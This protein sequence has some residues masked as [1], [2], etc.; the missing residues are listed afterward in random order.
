M[1]SGSKIMTIHEGNTNS[2]CS[3]L[4]ER[5]K[6]LR[7]WQDEQRKEISLNQSRGACEMK[8]PKKNEFHRDPTNSDIEALQL[9][10]QG[11]MKNKV[12]EQRGNSSEGEN[13]TSLLEFQQSSSGSS[14]T[15]HRF[16]SENS[17]T[18]E[19]QSVYQDDRP[20]QEGLSCQNVLGNISDSISTSPDLSLQEECKMHPVSENGQSKVVQTQDNQI[21]DNINIKKSIVSE[22]PIARDMYTLK[23]N[24]T[25][26]DDCKRKYQGLT[27]FISRHTV[28]NSVIDDNVLGINS[29][30]SNE[31]SVSQPQLKFTYLK[32]GQGTARFGM[33]PLRFRRAQNY[34]QEQA[35]ERE[36]FSGN[37]S[38][39][40]KSIDSSQN[41]KL[42]AG[43]VP[44]KMLQLQ[45]P[46]T[47]LGYEKCKEGTIMH[48]PA[49][50]D[51]PVIVTRSNIQQKRVTPTSENDKQLLKEQEELSAFE[52]L[53]ELADD[54]S[55][56]SNSSTV[57]RLLQRGLHSSSSTPLKSPSSTPSFSPTFHLLNNK[58]ILAKCCKRDDVIAK[59]SKMELANIC[60]DE[61]YRQQNQ[62]PLVNVSIVLEQ[63]KRFVRLEDLS[64]SGLSE[65]ELKSVLESFIESEN[66][67]NVG[68]VSCFENN[69]KLTSSNPTSTPAVNDEPQ[70][71]RPRVHFQPEGVQVLEY[72]LS[73]SDGENTLTDM[74]SITD[75]TDLV[76][77]SDLEVLTQIHVN[78]TDSEG[79]QKFQSLKE[80]HENETPDHVSSSGALQPIRLQFSPPC[81]PKN[82]ASHY[83]WSIFGKEEPGK[84]ANHS[85]TSQHVSSKGSRRVLISAPEAVQEKDKKLLETN[86][87][88]VI[89]SIER[90]ES[91]S[92]SKIGNHEEVETHKA[93]LMAKV[94]ELEKEIDFYKKG[95][96]KIKNLQDS[97]QSERS[98]LDHQKR[99]FQEEMAK[100]KVKFQEYLDAERNKLWKEKQS[101]RNPSVSS[102]REQSMEI[103]FLKEQ[104][105][106]LQE[107]LQKR[108]DLHN[109]AVKKLNEKIRLQE[110]EVKSLKLKN[111]SLQKSVQDMQ[112]KQKID[113][114]NVNKKP[115]VN[116]KGVIL[117]GK[118]K[119]KTK[120]ATI[121]SINKSLDKVPVTVS[122]PLIDR[123]ALLGDMPVQ[124]KMS[125]LGRQSPSNSLHQ[126]SNQE[127]NHTLQSF[128]QANKIEF[129][130]SIITTGRNKNAQESSRSDN[131]DKRR[132]LIGLH[133]DKPTNDGEEA[134]EIPVGTIDAGF[135][136][137]KFKPGITSV[138]ESSP[139]T[140]QSINIE[141]TELQLGDG[142]KEIIYANG[143]KKSIHS[144]G[145]IIISYYNGDKKEIHQDRTVYVYGTDRTSHTTF[146][147]GK[148]ILEFPNG[149]K[150]TRFTDGSSEIIFPDKTCKTVLPDGTEVCTLPNGTIVHTNADGFKVMEFVSGQKE[151]H[152]PEQKRR[153]YPD[154]TVK[155]LHSDGSTET[156]YKTGR[157]RVKDREGNIL[158][159]THQSVQ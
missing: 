102:V 36:I 1:E 54:S 89:E 39:N 79:A 3:A 13:S 153:E 78:A 133:E 27:N 71:A 23:C 156:R 57:I 44:V 42:K 148:E 5:L 73:E 53:E 143:N 56:S 97:L 21:L 101:V 77:T 33:K 118:S 147:N 22:F 25:N 55:F 117:T 120:T 51:E 58:K 110:L 86:G 37:P 45:D 35:E 94:C 75:D 83:I 76:T 137:S 38:V 34:V 124:N 129:S 19:D 144:D 99:S 96:V 123:Q 16:I 49:E 11:G 66:S 93:L 64:L 24:P 52:K 107:E 90:E 135:L 112:Q 85:K 140:Q 48:A 130:G 72:E 8:L 91:P 9:N 28:S 115:S 12:Y 149:Q 106:D 46:T 103:V 151:V 154:G 82:S 126:K 104:L 95:N 40:I 80:S 47:R 105:K 50:K 59:P 109:G 70:L 30:T 67:F 157:V 108:E 131:T 68:S 138:M 6:N 141:S 31:T 128:Q 125:G 7:R 61:S 4:L 88:K 87:S 18:V 136:S 41:Y 81:R 15:H 100:E 113:R 14:L 29:K 62:F 159:D 145:T 98:Q 150:E 134:K 132:D 43:N 127:K 65:E 17:N 122:D 139:Q 32:K 121:N 26:E 158:S 60:S 116:S 152:T 74:A 142:T 119:M 92:A 84:K 114:G 111:A 10:S 146:I 2:P 69:I 63:L 20:N 155:I